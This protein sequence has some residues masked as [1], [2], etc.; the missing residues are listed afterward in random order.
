[1]VFECFNIF[2]KFQNNFEFLV[3]IIVNIIKVKIMPGILSNEHL[4][5]K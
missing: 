2:F 1:M 5:N 4:T 3:L